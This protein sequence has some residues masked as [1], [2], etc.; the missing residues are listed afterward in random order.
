MACV[1]SFSFFY[2][3]VNRNKT[4]K[5]SRLYRYA[6]VC[7]F[8]KGLLFSHS[9]T[10]DSLWPHGLQHTRLTCPS[11]TP[12]SCSN[13]CPSSQSWHTTISSSVIPFFSCFQSSP[14]SGSFPMSQFLA[15]GGQSIRVSNKY[16][17]LISFRI[18]WF[19]L[20]PVQGPLKSLLQHHSSKTSALQR[21]AFSTVLTIAY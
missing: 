15:S 14:A 8:S 4:V 16:S 18:D 5:S 10:F 9:D 12:G 7:V 3:K 2:I 1:N 20:L 17:R 13:S 21:S 19:D 6:C 11:P